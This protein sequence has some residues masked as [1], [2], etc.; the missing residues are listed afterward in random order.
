[1][2]RNNLVKTLLISLA[3]LL[4]S[5]GKS[6][7]KNCYQCFLG[8]MIVSSFDLAESEIEDKK[9][10]NEV[11]SS[12]NEYYANIYLLKTQED[13]DEFFKTNTANIDMKE[14]HEYRALPENMMMTY[15]IAEVPEGYKAYKRSNIQGELMDQGLILLTDN[16][17]YY[18]SKPDIFYCQIDL[19]PEPVNTSITTFSFFYYMSSRY[20]DVIKSE[21]IRI[22]YNI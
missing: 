14:I 10:Q 2:K 18:A 7:E 20:S 21:N 19:K 5:C 13:V 1:M 15:F 11:T 16:F 6:V 17:Y 12:D 9:I 22:L 4:V 8:N 3:S